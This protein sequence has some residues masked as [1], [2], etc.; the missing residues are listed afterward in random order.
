MAKSD[1]AGTAGAVVGELQRIANI[2]MTECAKHAAE[3][4]EIQEALQGALAEVETLKKAKVAAQ[5][6]AEGK[7]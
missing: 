4:A 2:L 5:S 1:G 3:K 6:G 7:N